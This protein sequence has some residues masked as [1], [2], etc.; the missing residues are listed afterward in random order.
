MINWS[1]EI[2]QIE[3]VEDMMTVIVP[4]AQIVRLFEISHDNI[5]MLPIFLFILLLSKLLLKVFE[6]PP[7]IGQ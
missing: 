4:N 1:P 3:I 6:I 5:E 7:Q 2:G